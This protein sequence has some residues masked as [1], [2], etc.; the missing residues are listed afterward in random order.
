MAIPDTKTRFLLETGDER[1]CRRSSAGLNAWSACPK[2]V[3]GDVH[4]RE[5]GAAPPPRGVLQRHTEIAICRTGGPAGRGGS[6]P[7]SA[8]SANHPTWFIDRHS[9]ESRQAV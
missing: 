6:V 7:V 1:A 8:S 4:R 3:M 5:S 2:Y 9:P